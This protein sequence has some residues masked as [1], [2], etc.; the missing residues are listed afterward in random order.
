MHRRGA[1]PPRAA[2]HVRQ[3]ATQCVTTALRVDR[4]R[5]CRAACG[6]RRPRAPGL[7]VMLPRDR[8]DPA[9]Q[10]HSM[11]LQT[12]TRMAEDWLGRLDAALRAGDARAAAALFDGDCYWRDL[13][14]FTWNIR[15]ME[16]RADIEAMLREAL[17]SVRPH[18]WR[19]EGE[20]TQANDVTEAW[21]AFRDRARPRPRPR[22]PEGR[23]L[24]DADDDAGRAEGL[25]GEARRDAP[26]RRRARRASRAGAPGR[27]S[28]P[29]RQAELGYTRQPYC[30]IVGGGQGGIALGARLKRLERADAGHRQAPA[31][32]RRMARALQVAL[33]ARPGL[34]RP[35]ALPAL[36]RPLA[37][38]H[39]QGQDGR[40]AGGLHRS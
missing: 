38:V 7:L 12:P 39:A 23:S 5:R 24:L 11:T 20:A 9:P 15:T 2:K 34:V 31:R 1:T 40:L 18:G 3:E 8:S 6:T 35:P 27:R 32:G 22:P 30:L 4:A 29:R 28:A 36:P 16:G 17:A 25:R 10:E 33:P 13:V 26:T 14:A 21:F 19:L 37:G